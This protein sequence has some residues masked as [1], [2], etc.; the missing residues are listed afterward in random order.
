MPSV[1]LSTAER[2]SKLLDAFVQ[3]ADT[4]VD[5]YDI[6]DVLHELVSHCVRL[7]GFATAGILLSNQRGGLQ[8]VASSTEQTRML[9]LYQ[10]QTSEGPC[11]DCVH[12]GEP[13]SAADL[14][15]E[16]DHWPLFVHHALDLGFAAAHAIPMRLRHETIGAL[17][18]FGLEPQPLPEQDLRAA[19]ALA[20]TATIG[21]LQ[22][23]AI[24]R[25]EVLTEQLQVALI[26][27]VAIEQAKGILAQAGNLDMDQA[28]QA[29]RSYGRRRS[30]RLSD[31]AHQLASG[32]IGPDTV[33]TD[34]R[35]DDS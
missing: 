14:A 28:F 35:R 26:N 11:W 30:T 27:R 24:H 7:L 12:S 18:L 10:I 23:R 29:L 4:L 34:R 13:V 19:R 15:A 3:M 9:E 17:N 21:I 33:L 5:D 25:G 31:I 16:A 20:D 32:V 6:A 1:P 22:E 2:E 8:V